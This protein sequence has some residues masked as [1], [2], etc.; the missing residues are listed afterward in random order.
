MTCNPYRTIENIITNGSVQYDSV[1][2]K[3]IIECIHDVLFAVNQSIEAKTDAMELL[4][5]LQGAQSRNRWIKVLREE[6]LV[7]WNEVVVAQKLFYE[8]GYRRENLELNFNLL[9]IILNSVNEEKIIRNIVQ[10]QN[11]EIA[12]R[13]IWMIQRLSIFLIKGK[14]ML[15]IGLE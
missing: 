1:Q 13:K 4:C 15:I 7:R 6:L 2:M 8:S 12:A 14:A 10:I 9:N 3:I 5:V 11:S